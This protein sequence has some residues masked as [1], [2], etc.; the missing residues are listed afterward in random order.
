MFCRPRRP[1]RTKPF[2]LPEM[3]TDCEIQDGHRAS[4]VWKTHAERC[5]QQ[6]SGTVKDRR[7]VV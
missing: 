4:A 5:E 6:T 3:H 1:K 2:Q 7:Q